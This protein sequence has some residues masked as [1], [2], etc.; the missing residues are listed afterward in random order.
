MGRKSLQPKLLLCFS[1]PIIITIILVIAAT[2]TSMYMLAED[3][4]TS[5]ID[6]FSGRLRRQLLVFS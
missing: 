3:W 6:Q 2:V 5:G 1:I 4:V